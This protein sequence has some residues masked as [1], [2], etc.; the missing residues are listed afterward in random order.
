[1][2]TTSKY[3]REQQILPTDRNPIKCAFAVK[4]YNVCKIGASLLIHYSSL[5][6]LQ[7]SLKS[8]GHLRL[9]TKYIN[10]Y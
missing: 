1:M 4:A 7:D 6:G 10:F 8:L 3:T 5:Q 9:A 2:H